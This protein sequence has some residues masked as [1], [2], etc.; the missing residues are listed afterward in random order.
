M[1]L[2]MYTNAH[3]CKIPRACMPA[4]ATIQL[5]TYFSEQHRRTSCMSEMRSGHHW[6][7]GKI[8]QPS[9]KQC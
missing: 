8:S 3:P 5:N 7:L 1:F 2:I 6:D 4:F 9:V